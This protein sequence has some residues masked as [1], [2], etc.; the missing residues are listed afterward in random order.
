MLRR[1]SG[2]A[3]AF[4]LPMSAMI[5]SLAACSYE[6][7]AKTDADYVLPDSYPANSASVSLAARY[8]SLLDLAAANTLPGVTMAV[9]APSAYW[10]GSS[11]KIDAAN[12]IDAKRYSR[13][14]VGSISKTFTAA[15]VLLLQEEGK[16]DI[17]AL[18]SDYLDDDLA[19]RILGEHKGKV[20]IH[21]LLNHRSGI[22]NIGTT[23]NIVETSAVLGVWINDRSK[24]WTV[25]QQLELFFDKPFLFAPGAGYHYSNIGYLLLGRIIERVEGKTY[26]AVLQ[27][28]ILSPL[29]MAYTAMSH[30]GDSPSGLA[31]GYDALYGDSK[32][33]DMTDYY[34]ADYDSAG[35]IVSNTKDLAIFFRALFDGTLLSKESAASMIEEMSP[36][37]DVSSDGVTA[38]SYYGMGMH[39]NVCNDGSVYYSHGGF[40]MGYA[41]MAMYFP[42]TQTCVVYLQNCFD[43]PACDGNAVLTTKAMCDIG[44]GT[45]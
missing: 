13:Y 16:L 26:D 34:N 11:G 17:D 4:L 43:S 6:L 44:N 20:T 45:F 42:A 35:G 1:R 21:Q 23:A 10:A 29:G 31:R 14:R 36:S 5:I 9:A 15:L 41:S 18:A 2:A 38:L 40:V 24:T 19:S 33:Y 7:P 3:I 12:G 22:G 30:P 37:T 32:L 27:E 8:Q 28:R 39:K 25:R